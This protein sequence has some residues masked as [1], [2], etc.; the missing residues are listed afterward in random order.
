M[1][2]T[3]LVPDIH[4]RP[5]GGNIYNRRVAAGGQNGAIE[6]VPWRPDADGGDLDRP[7]EGVLVVDSLL[8]RHEE[9]LRALR[10][11][12][13]VA[14][15]VLLA[16]YLHCIDPTE[17]DPPAAAT[18]RAVLPLFDGAVT[19]SRYARR[20]LVDEG[21]AKKRIAVVPPGLDDAYRAPV[22]DRAGPEHVVD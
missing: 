15:L 22:P 8:V 2:V 6:V 13:P 3:L 20:A 5:R 9:A 10:R 12:H 14:T 11:A 17:R 19:T 16:H 4:D 21:M 1:H 7:D 18:E